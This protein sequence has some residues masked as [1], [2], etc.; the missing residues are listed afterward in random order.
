MKH[1][2]ISVLWYYLL[3]IS[4]LCFNDVAIYFVFVFL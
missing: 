2:K 1:L 4:A 3:I